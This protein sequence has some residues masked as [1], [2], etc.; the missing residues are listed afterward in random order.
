MDER[1]SVPLVLEKGEREVRRA[2]GVKFKTYKPGA[3]L[4]DRDI[5]LHTT[6]V[7][8]LTDRRLIHYA[9]LPSVARG[10]VFELSLSDTTGCSVK[11]PWLEKKKIFTVNTQRVVWVYPGLTE[12]IPFEPLAD[13]IVLWDIEQP[14][15]LRSE[16]MEQVE[17]YKGSQPPKAEKCPSCATNIPAG[18]IFCP[19][20]GASVTP[21]VV[22]PVKKLFLEN[23]KEILQLI[24]EF[25]TEKASQS[26]RVEF[27]K[28]MVDRTLPYIDKWESIYLQSEAVI[29][30]EYAVKNLYPRVEVNIKNSNEYADTGTRL[31]SQAMR[32]RK[33]GEKCEIWLLRS[34]LFLQVKTTSYRHY[35]GYCSGYADAVCTP[36]HG[37]G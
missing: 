11:K 17:R 15:V 13:H 25:E 34:G 31:Y 9:T 6:G 8:A 27:L 35:D 14:E 26:Q 1:D 22:A 23:L 2:E 16:I 4:W 30:E 18:A 28:K 10:H 7:L 37:S 12:P 21:G 36:R 33:D 24:E 29:E 20:C 32:S 19:N 5:L 3:E